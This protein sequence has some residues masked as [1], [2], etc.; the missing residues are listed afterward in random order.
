MSSPREPFFVKFRTRYTLKLLSELCHYILL[1]WCLIWKKALVEEFP[2]L[3]IY[4]SPIDVLKLTDKVNSILNEFENRSI[5]LRNRS[6]GIQG[7]HWVSCAIG[8]WSILKDGSV[9]S[10]NGVPVQLCPLELS[11]RNT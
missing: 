10:I 6:I 3:L 8:K 7:M 1:L 11:D 5:L 2:R 4:Y 9:R